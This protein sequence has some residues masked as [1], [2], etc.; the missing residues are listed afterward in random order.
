MSLNEE[1]EVD[2]KLCFVAGYHTQHLTD[3]LNREKQLSS[4]LSHI[5]LHL[6]GSVKVET[7]PRNLGRLGGALVLRGFQTGRVCHLMRWTNT[8]RDVWAAFIII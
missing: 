8:S 7:R 6:I 3:K 1:P 4:C 5:L 2:I